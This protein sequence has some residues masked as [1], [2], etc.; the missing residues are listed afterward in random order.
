MNDPIDF[1]IVPTTA[2]LEK[3]VELYGDVGLRSPPYQRGYE[4][5]AWN[6]QR[7]VDTLLDE[8]QKSKGEVNPIFLGPIQISEEEGKNGQISIGDGRQRLTTLSLLEAFLIHKSGESG[9]C[10]ISSLINKQDDSK[11]FSTIGNMAGIEAYKTLSDINPSV[12]R[13]RKADKKDADQC[14]DI[15]LRNA[16]Y[17][18]TILKKIENRKDEVK[19]FLDYLKRNVFFIVVTVKNRDLTSIIKIFDSMNSTG[20]PLS[21]EAMFKLRLY[22]HVHSVDRDIETSEIME[23]IN[24]TYKLVEDYNKN[25]DATIRISMSDVLW[26]FRL[27]CVAKKDEIVLENESKQEI[28]AETFLMPTLQFF[29]MLFSLSGTKVTLE[30][31]REY[32]KSHIAFYEQAYGDVSWGEDGEKAFYYSLLHCFGYTRYSSFW[33]LPIVCYALRNKEVLDALKECGPVFQACLA[34]SICYDKANKKFRTKFLFEVLNKLYKG[35]SLEDDSDNKIKEIDGSRRFW[36]RVEENVYDSY[37]QAYLILAILGIQDEIAKGKTFGEALNL[38]FMTSGD[39]R[40]QIEHIY[41]KD[42]WK[43]IADEALKSRLNGLGN[44][45]PLEAKINKGEN[46]AGYP[47]EK[48]ADG[49]FFNKSKSIQSVKSLVALYDSIK[50]TGINLDDPVVW[51]EKI[52]KGR[53]EDSKKKLT[54]L[55]KMLTFAK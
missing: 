24:G 45:V 51:D 44:L 6:I 48:F 55:M 19:G 23:E 17:I 26:G 28:K 1:G 8:F 49:T 7:F 33:I 37:R 22:A 9:E 40:P 27:Y 2:S 3:L 38:Y 53:F 31:F 34:W 54:G 29:E 50:S 20:Q 13:L 14:K 4:W 32:T 41:A 25:H 16:R 21:D 11:L 35:D 42:K 43:G 46:K 52:V 12:L 36:D 5:N 39:N 15:Y 47:S 18:A 30:L 10:S